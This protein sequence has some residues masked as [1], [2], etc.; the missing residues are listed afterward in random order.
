[1]FTNALVVDKRDRLT[2]EKV[3]CVYDLDVNENII[4]VYYVYH[5]L[6][7]DNSETRFFNVSQSRSVRVS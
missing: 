1:M 4:G 2:V 3:E 7:N 6:L 5:S